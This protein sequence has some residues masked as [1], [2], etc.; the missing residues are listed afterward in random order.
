MRMETGWTLMLAG[1]LSAG[2]MVGQTNAPQTTAGQTGTGSTAGQTGAG[3]TAGTGT[4]G[5]GTAGTG[6]GMGQA[7][8]SATQGSMGQGSYPSDN[9][10]VKKAI[11]GNVSEIDAA[12]MALQKS[13][14]DQ[15]KQFAQKMIDDHTKMLDDMH[16]LAMQDNIKYEDKPSPMGQ[17][18]AAKLQTLDGS[19]FDKA[20]V[21]GMVKDHKEDV[22][23]FMTEI[24]HGKKQDVKDAASKSLPIIQQHLSMIEGIKKSMSA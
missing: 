8:D 20:Y 2:T 14:N 17:K 5:T 23:E 13:Q 1:V 3:S 21:D 19:A 16:T 10:F 24:N 6:A 7:T 22:K 12:K 4:S 18:L 15:V 11:M 9:T